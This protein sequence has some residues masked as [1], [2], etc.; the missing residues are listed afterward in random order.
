MDHTL[1]TMNDLKQFRPLSDEQKARVRDSV[2]ETKRLLAKET[3][4]L[5][6]NQSK[7]YIIYLVNHIRMLER[8]LEIAA[9]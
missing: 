8:E 5:P 2:K 1:S 9:E 4:Y 3:S 6:E 7:S